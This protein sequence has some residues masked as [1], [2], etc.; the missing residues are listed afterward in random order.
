MTTEEK[1]SLPAIL[2]NTG[3]ILQGR[4]HP[5]IRAQIKYS[6]GERA[7]EEGFITNEGDF[8]GRKEAVKIFR[9]AGQRTHTGNL[10]P[11]DVEELDSDHMF[12][13]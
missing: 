7:E 11:E 8:V 6:E 5:G 2:T 10:L 1:I 12:K 3:R 9:K 4:S 13:F